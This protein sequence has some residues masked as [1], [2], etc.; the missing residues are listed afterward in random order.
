M[1]IN[2]YRYSFE[3]QAVVGRSICL[4]FTLR[5]MLPH[6]HTTQLRDTTVL[7]FRSIQHITC[8]ICC[9]KIHCYHRHSSAGGCV[10]HFLFVY[11]IRIPSPY[12]SSS[13]LLF[14]LILF[15]LLSSPSS[16][17][18]LLLLLLLLL[19]HNPQQR[20]SSLIKASENTFLSLAAKSSCDA[21]QG[22]PPEVVAK[23]TD[24]MSLTTRL[25]VLP[26]NSTAQIW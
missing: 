23:V 6:P 11:Y 1:S 19:P 22:V 18:P 20:L 24:L 10:T 9:S 4:G 16:S 26:Q 8:K 17:S 21:Y 13:F 7:S 14:F 5:M 2:A 15:L 3:L 25:D 12:S